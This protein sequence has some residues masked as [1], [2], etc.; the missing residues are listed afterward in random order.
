MPALPEPPGGVPGHRSPPPPSTEAPPRPRSPGAPWR[1]H[2][3][4]Q[5]PGPAARGRTAPPSGRSRHG[6]GAGGQRGLRAGGVLRDSRGLRAPPQGAAVKGGGLALAP[7]WGCRRAP[8]LWARLAPSAFVALSIPGAAAISQQHPQP[9]P[10]LLSLSLLLQLPHFH[11][12]PHSFHRSWANS[13]PPAQPA[14]S[15]EDKRAAPSR[16]SR[17]TSTLSDAVPHF[18]S[19]RGT[20]R[21]GGPPHDGPQEL[22]ALLPAGKPRGERC[23]QLP[24]V[25]PAFPQHPTSS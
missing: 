17:K 5:P 23:V 24:A 9:L 14:H 6:A 13:S 12:L 18:P 21:R 3:A 25:N 10:L 19:K 15:H 1:P 7:S 8:T 11:K 2:G 16:G 4:A 22:W 20:Q